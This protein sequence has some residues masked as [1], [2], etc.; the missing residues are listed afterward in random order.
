MI[1]DGLSGLE[2]SMPDIC[3]IGAGPVGI[4]LALDL[5]RLGC[6]ALVLESGATRPHQ[7]TQQLA[8]ASIAVPQ[9]HVPMALAVHRGLGGTSNLWGGR[10]VPMEPI[11]FEPRP[12]IPGSSWPIGMADIAPYLS[13]ACDYLGCGEAMFEAPLPGV[14][15]DNP[16]FRFDHLERWSRR[17]RLANSHARQLRQSR[18]IDLRL[19]ATVT[20]FTFRADGNVDRVR[21]RQA[22]GREA[23]VAPRRVVLAAGGLENTRLMLAA[24]LDNP[25]RF[26]GPDGPLGRYYMGHLYGSAAEM[27]IRSEALDAGMDYFRDPAGYYV[28]RRFTPSPD[29]QRRAGLSNVA[30]WPDDPP[31]HDPRHR[32]GILSF[33][34]LALS[35]PWL[36]RLIVVESIRSHYVG[37][38]PARRRAHI[39]NMLRDAPRTVVFVPAF[40]YRRYIAR[41]HMPGF[42]QRNAARRYAVRF[43]AEHLPD[44]QSRATLSGQRDALGLPRLAIDL[45]YREQD[46]E[47]LIRAHDCFAEWL[48][49][50]C[51]G[52]MTWSVPRE[53]RAAHIIAQCYDGHHQIGLTRMGATSRT[54]VVDADCRAFGAANL[55]VAGSSVFPTSGAANP[56]LTAVAL[57]L[58]LAALLASS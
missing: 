10:C 14:P 54:G 38:S 58:R 13:G 50:A 37:S 24:Q 33:A 4:S 23:Q 46:A 12:A 52:Q 40:L 32:N 30:L 48:E 15:T 26:G 39:G 1:T 18:H 21:V 11:D 17:P 2:G 25:H 31:I 41:P 57:A 20:G 7:A 6:S 44:P 34:Y 19:R 27:T 56:T 8:E 5:A 53:Q 51:L 29:L 42:F 35:V 28:R 22:C 49:R 36:G 45:R 9:H 3:I 55:F 43:H 16:D 47:P